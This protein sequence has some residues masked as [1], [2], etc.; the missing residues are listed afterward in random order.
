MTNIDR[1]ADILADA[2]RV[3]YAG[4]VWVLYGDTWRNPTTGITR[5]DP[6]WTAREAYQ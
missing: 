2:V 5:D 4:H 1:A 3:D 6:K